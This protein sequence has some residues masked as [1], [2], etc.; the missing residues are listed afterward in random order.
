MK[1][2]GITGQNGFIGS[3]LYNT[4][5]LF[6]DLYERVVFS[7][8]FFDN[9]DLMDEFVSSCDTIVHTAG[10]NRDAD[11]KRIFEAN[12]WMAEKLAA[13]IER[14]RSHKHV[15][16]TSST[17]EENDNI[18]GLSKKAAREILAN[19]IAKNGGK[20]T[21][22]IIPNVFGPFSTPFYNSV[23]ATFCYQLTHGEVPKVEVDRELKLIYVSEL[24]NEICIVVANG[25]EAD[26]YLIQ[27]TTSCRVSDI[28]KLLFSYKGLYHE[29]NI[30]PHFNNTFEL[31]LFN[32]FRSFEDIGSKFPVK[33]IRYEDSRGIFSEIIRLNQGGQ[34]SFSTTLPGVTRGN[35]FHTRKIERFAVIKGDAQI[36]L[37]KFGTSE[38]FD[39]Y[40]SGEAPAFVDMPIWYTHNIKNIGTDDLYTIFWINEFY[41]PEDTDTFFEQV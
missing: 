26:N 4:L 16:F 31:N 32:T 40:L 3:H 39:F 27:H 25:V 10:V 33:F 7:R 30:M 19:T 29:N 2:I 12:V 36:Q 37:R 22:M 15:I 24:V 14:T 28:L 20:F 35:H 23:I 11:E 34:V 8:T 17:Q 21:G 5:G 9:D 6:T 1:K 41:N 38:V 18:Y 13:S